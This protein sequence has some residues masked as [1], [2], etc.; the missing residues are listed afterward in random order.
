MAKKTNIATQKADEAGEKEKGGSDSKSCLRSTSSDDTLF[1]PE[2]KLKKRTGANEQRGG[3]CSGADLG[4]DC[5]LF[6]QM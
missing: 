2:I 3:Q 5:A 6:A 4:C 1:I